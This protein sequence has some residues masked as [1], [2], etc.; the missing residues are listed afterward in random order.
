MNNAGDLTRSALPQVGRSWLRRN[1][2]PLVAAAS[3][4]AVGAVTASV[5]LA[6]LAKP[7]NTIDKMVPASADV[8][9]LANLDPSLA[10][11]V[12]LMRVLHR[13]PQAST[14]KA[15]TDAIDKALKGTGLSF[16]GDIQPWLGAEAGV[17]ARLNYDSTADSTTAVL[18]ALSRN[19]AKAKA[20]LAKLRSTDAG[21]KLQWRDETYNGFAIS[22]GTPSASSARPAAYSYV[23]HV[24][25]IATS[26]AAIHDVIDTEQGRTPRLTD[27]A[28]YRATMAALPSDR[29]GLVYVHGRSLVTGIKKQLAKAP[30]VSTPIMGN[31][32]DLD[33][34][35]GIGA[36]LSAAGNGLKADLL[37]KLDSSKLS[38]ATRQALSNAGRPDAVL[39]WIPRGTDAFVAVGNLNRTIQTLMD[40]SKSDPSIVASTDAIG[41]TGPGGILPHLSGA[42]ALEAQV[43]TSG[44]PSGAM[45]LGT[46]DAPSLKAFFGKLL[47]LTKSGSGPSTTTYRGVVISSIRSPQ[48]G[49]AG[50][51]PSYAVVDGMGVLGSSLA[52][53]EAVI[54]AHQSGETI[55]AD[56]TYKAATGG[57]LAKPAAIVYVNVGG[58][59]RAVRGLPLKTAGLG[60]DQKGVASVEPVRALMLTASSQADQAAER[61]FLL[62][63]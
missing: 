50:V 25:V 31:V 35:V 10:Q 30:A 28:D 49:L 6:L 55:T 53:V 38:P 57:S 33:A 48:L 40:A 13:F 34:F 60:I 61:L 56:S 19:D 7:A 2:L 20:A 1:R 26:G 12:N 27:T 63:N 62:I 14:D 15:I 43:G 37:I 51:V 41:L 5:A 44:T 11:K 39:T 21:K 22:I 59:L 45:L 42:A 24:V 16:S 47:G 3:V 8:V 46:D 32:A 52:E 18:Y 9:V 17:S 29:V 23:D 54:D 4:L 58:L 36:T